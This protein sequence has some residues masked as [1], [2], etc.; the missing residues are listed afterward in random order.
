MRRPRSRGRNNL[1]PAKDRMNLAILQPVADPRSQRCPYRADVA[2]LGAALRARHHAVALTVVDACDESRLASLMATTRPEL[3]LIYV[4][5]LAADMAFRIAG[6][7]DQFHGAPLIPFGPHASLRPD[8]C[9]SMRGAE[10]VAVG[11]AD[12]SIPRYLALRQHSLDH[13]RAPGLWVKCE[14]GIMRNPPAPPPES[15]A[16]EAPPARDLYPFERIMD[17]AGFIQI[18]VSRGAEGGLAPAAAAA[19]QQVTGWPTTAA[20]PLLHRP[21]EAV[22]DEMVAVVDAHFDL[23]GFRVENERWAGNREWLAAFAADYATQIGLPLRTTLHAPD[24]TAD[25]ATHLAKAGCKEAAMPVG[26]GS[27]MIRN[28][29]LGLHFMDE[30]ILAA[31]DALRAAGVPSVACVEVGAPY[32]TRAS[33]DQTLA[34]LKRM[35]PDRVEARLHFP[36]PGTPS[37]KAARENGWLVSDAAAAHIAG[38]PAVALPR[39]G[40]EEVITACE[41]LPYA[42]LRPMTAR[43][44]RLGRRVRIGRRG[45]LYEL[46]VKPFLAP[47]VRRGK[48]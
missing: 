24:V 43:L 28:D 39:L 22:L 2:A 12:L 32:E 47:P 20:W 13:L 9:L 10:A 46:A 7:L 5:S 11:P 16:G 36:A 48:P 18:R 15:L 41:S 37:D 44:I 3:T 17:P 40:P 38:R 27:A 23:V 26:S 25:V 1:R 29:I 6:V 30:T 35:R 19:P 42:V 33:L 34:L 14:T 4:D 8:E 45:T 31:F 21:V